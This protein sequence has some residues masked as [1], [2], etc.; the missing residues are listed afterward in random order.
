[1][2]ASCDASSRRVRH[3]LS[4][5]PFARHIRR[6]HTRCFRFRVRTQQTL[7]KRK[8]GLHRE[9]LTYPNSTEQ[10]VQRS[11][12]RGDHLPPFVLLLDE[13][14]RSL[15]HLYRLGRIGRKPLNALGKFMRRIRD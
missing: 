6:R 13:C 1:M 15:R 10:L 14:S 3:L 4:T 2:R 12:E 9:D 11:K 7:R 5:A 8:E